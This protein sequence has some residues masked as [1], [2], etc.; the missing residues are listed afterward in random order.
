[1]DPRNGGDL[2]SSQEGVYAVLRRGRREGGAGYGGCPVQVGGGDPQDPL[3]VPAGRYDEEDQGG[4]RALLPEDL[5]SVVGTPGPGEGGGI[6][7]GWPSRGVHASPA[8]GRG[9]R[10]ARW[11]TPR[12]QR[13][14]GGSAS[15]RR[16]PGWSGG[17]GWAPRPRPPR[18][19]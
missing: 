4:A 9:T 19:P 11:G 16:T 15:C 6:G 3:R 18:T 13:R 10:P 12:T 1:M 14:T 7:A 5:L 8:G 2:P 17:G